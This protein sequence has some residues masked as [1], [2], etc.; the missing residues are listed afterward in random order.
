MRWRL[1]KAKSNIF[2]IL[3]HFS[4]KNSVFIPFLPFCVHT[5]VTVTLYWIMANAKRHKHMFNNGLVRSG[6]VVFLRVEPKS[7]RVK[8]V[9]IQNKPKP[10]AIKERVQQGINGS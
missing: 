8:S 5:Q 3:A 10:V 4:V 2:I 1:R 7:W 9:I 6:P